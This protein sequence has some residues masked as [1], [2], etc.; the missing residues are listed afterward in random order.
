MNTFADQPV[1]KY[2]KNARCI[3]VDTCNHA[4]STPKLVK[5]KSLNLLLIG[6]ALE[7]YF[8]AV[9]LSRLMSSSLRMHASISTADPILPGSASHTAPLPLRGFQAPSSPRSHH[10]PRQGG[11]SSPTATPC[12]QGPWSNVAASS[13][14][15]EFLAVKAPFHYV[16]G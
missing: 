8:R 15:I 7:C 12:E 13:H 5:V 9:L 11:V 3:V 2:R 16:F 4:L 1:Q 6:P 14:M 10:L